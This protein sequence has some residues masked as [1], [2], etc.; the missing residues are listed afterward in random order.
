MYE[1][2]LFKMIKVAL[3]DHR[4]DLPFRCHPPTIIKIRLNVLVLLREEYSQ[5]C[6]LFDLS[7]HNF[8]VQNFFNVVI[9]ND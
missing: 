4:L 7:H 5:H 6:I 9:N 1:Y 2:L 8:P 3:S